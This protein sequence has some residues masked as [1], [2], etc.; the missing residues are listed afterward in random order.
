MLYPKI[1][2]KSFPL[3]NSKMDSGSAELRLKRFRISTKFYHS[4]RKRENL[5]REDFMLNQCSQNQ[6]SFLTRQQPVCT[7]SFSRIQLK[8]KTQNLTLSTQS[9][10]S[11]TIGFTSFLAVH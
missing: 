2:I 9:K 4:M 5:E 11:E 6:F 3:K 7:K 10:T 8:T 1:S